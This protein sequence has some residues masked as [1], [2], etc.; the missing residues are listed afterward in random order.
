MD[1]EDTPA[2][3]VL[4][5]GGQIRLDQCCDLTTDHHSNFITGGVSGLFTALKLAENG[6]QNVTVLEV[7]VF[8][9]VF[10]H[11]SENLL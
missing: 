8:S 5:I 4:I 11:I 9:F 2:Q 7:N 1:S 10:L 6:H 3:S